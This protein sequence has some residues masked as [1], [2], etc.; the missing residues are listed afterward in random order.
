MNNI[1]KL[2]IGN[3][4]VIGAAAI[5]AS[6]NV[7]NASVITMQTRPI[8]ATANASAADYLANWN[9]A[10]AV[11]PVAPGGYCDTTLTA[12]NEVSNHAQLGSL[13]NCGGASAGNISFHFRMNLN[14]SNA[15]AGLWNFKFQNDF[16][17]GGAVFL[18]GV[19]VDYKPFN[20]D[21]SNPGMLFTLAL[22]LA[23]GTRVLDIYG[24]ENCCDGFHYGDYL[25]NGTYQHLS[26]NDIFTAEVPEPSQLPLMLSG[27]L[28]LFGMYWVRKPRIG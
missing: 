22:N 9:A 17:Y 13:Q 3:A 23:S 14:V 8:V 7:A 19:A 27:L 15:L 21:G 20:L 5:L 24:Q 10:L 18:D 4:L 26:N 6:T 2:A 25:L 11:Y 28:A 16:G 12:F 1:L